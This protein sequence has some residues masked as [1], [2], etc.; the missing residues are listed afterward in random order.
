MEVFIDYISLENKYNNK[1]INKNKI[2]IKYQPVKFHN[3]NNSNNSNNSNNAI[4][5]RF[6]HYEVCNILVSR[7][8]SRTF[9]IEYT[10]WKLFQLVQYSLTNAD[11][12]EWCT[13]WV[14]NT[15][16]YQVGIG[17]IARLHHEQRTVYGTIARL[18]GCTIAT[19]NQTWTMYMITLS[20][21][22]RCHDYI[23]DNV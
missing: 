4:I 21:V 1:K 3:D 20:M 8:Q 19:L 12:Y 22:V 7:I 6:Y 2:K 14:S 5:N 17:T 23:M 15:C 16:L 10:G 18:H 13:H 9:T 11:M